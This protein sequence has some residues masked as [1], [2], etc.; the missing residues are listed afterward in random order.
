MNTFP[1]WIVL[2]ALLTIAGSAAH[3][4]SSVSPVII[5]AFEVAGQ[6]SAV[7]QDGQGNF[8]GTEE[9]GGAYGMGSIFEIS[10]DGA[11]STVYH[12]N[13][14]NGSAPL[15]LTRR[16]GD[17]FFG[18]TSAG[19][20]DPQFTTGGVFFEFQS[21]ATSPPVTRASTRATFTDQFSSPSGRTGKGNLYPLTLDLNGNFVGATSTGGVDGSGLFYRVTPSG[22]ISQLHDANQPAAPLARLGNDFYGITRTGGTSGVGSL[23]KLAQDGTLTTIY[24]FTN[25]VNGGSPAAVIAGADGN[26]YVTTDTGG[27]SD[28]KG[29][30]VRITPAGVA[31]NLTSFTVNH[32][33]PSLGNF[34]NNLLVAAPSGMLFYGLIGKEFYSIS[35]DCVFTDLGPAPVPPADASLAL[36]DDGNCYISG[37]DL[38]LGATHASVTR[39][40]PAGVFT[41]LADLKKGLGTTPEASLTPVG[42]GSF[43]GTTFTGGSNDLGTVYRLAANGTVTSLVDFNGTNGANPQG[44]VT[45]DGL[46]NFYGTTS[47]QNNT[48]NNGTIFKID[49]AGNFSFQIPPVGAGPMGAIVMGPDGNLYG[50]TS[51]GGSG[52]F[53][54]G[55]IFR[56]T[57]TAGPLAADFGGH[58]VGRA[59]WQHH[60]RAGRQPIPYRRRRRPNRQWHPVQ[61]HHQRQRPHASRLL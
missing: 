45:A 49:P 1:R 20:S 6:P 25:D 34:G 50:T 30:V 4:Q 33:S 14:A 12:F 22:M 13:G 57:P 2:C 16:T 17:D 35:S 19:G 60:I 26:A 61:L 39:A 53:R 55:T 31:T 15:G 11:S 8:F 48:P 40:T 28:S 58:R 37:A 27:N 56:I 9:H 23:F 38:N 44:P 21:L 59:G 41:L 32:P 29:A 52:N 47:P 43:I 51:K 46:G 36:G 18:V 3:S 42:D 24:S 5:H 10:P 54:H 7:V